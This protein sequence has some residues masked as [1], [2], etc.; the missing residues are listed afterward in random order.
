MASLHELAVLFPNEPYFLGDTMGVM[1]DPARHLFMTAAVATLAGLDRPLRVLEIGSWIGFSTLTWAQALD[2]LPHKGTILCIDPWASYWS[3]EEV[4][5]GGVMATMDFMSRADLS[6]NLFR[7]NLGF[8]PRSIR[9]DH[10]RGR[11]ADILPYLADG[12][13]DLIFVEAITGI[14]RSQSNCVRRTGC[15]PMA[16]CYAATIWSSRRRQPSAPGW[17]RPCTIPRMQ[18]PAF[19]TIQE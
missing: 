13:F 12:A 7:H 17:I 5:A 11:S 19:V 2:D 8:A 15:W 16:G 10:M 18:E 9:I 4:Q 14:R 1:G 6:Y 3:P